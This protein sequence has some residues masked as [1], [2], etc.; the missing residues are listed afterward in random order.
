MGTE[1]YTAQRKAKNRGGGAPP[2]V[3]SQKMERVSKRV[4]YSA[5]SLLHLLFSTSSVTAIL[6]QHILVIH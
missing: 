1:K 3:C 4:I 2:N 6:D 5:Y